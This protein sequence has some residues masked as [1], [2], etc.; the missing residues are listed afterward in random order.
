MHCNSGQHTSCG[1]KN[2]IADTSALRA[3]AIHV[4]NF[5][6]PTQKLANTIRQAATDNYF[7]SRLRESTT[8]S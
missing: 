2:A 3:I 5:A 8:S 1:L 7:Q 4:F 6:L